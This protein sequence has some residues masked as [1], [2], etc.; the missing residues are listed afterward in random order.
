[1]INIP[2]PT[3]PK[4]REDVVGVSTSA[5]LKAKNK[6]REELDAQ[7]EEFLARGGK[8]NRVEVRASVIPDVSFHAANKMS[9]KEQE[10]R[11]KEAK[12]EAAQK[13][14]EEAE[15]ARKISERE[16]KIREAAKAVIG[17]G[18]KGVEPRYSGRK[19]A[20]WESRERIV[21]LIKM[22]GLVQAEIQR[23]LGLGQGTLCMWLKGTST[24]DAKQAKRVE[25]I[26]HELVGKV[27]TAESQPVPSPRT[28][29]EPPTVPEQ[30]Q[31]VCAQAPES[32]TVMPLIRHHL[33]RELYDLQ[34]DRSTPQRAEAVLALVDA[35][36][37]SFEGQDIRV[38]QL[39]AD[40]AAKLIKL[41][42][43][44]LAEEP[45][46]LE[47]R[48]WPHKNRPEWPNR[49]ATRDLIKKHKLNIEA[50]RRTLGHAQGVIN[51][52]LNAKNRPNPDQAKALE[53][54]VHTL[55]KE[56]RRK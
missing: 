24:P 15:K 29:D 35:I 51:C 14:R 39:T 10:A 41:T 45:A 33:V 21:A 12:A 42:Q 36:V 38:D 37:D 13:A 53:E 2:E 6:T 48:E 22:H 31:G 4:D 43:R 23:A 32:A 28:E 25:A 34:N 16:A 20:P 46:P 50:M 1:M 19:R 18:K 11:A 56:G 7:V 30:S 54:L 27:V 40:A 52:W 8:I 49:E 47:K 17:D 26:V 44:K 55:T 3:R 5:A 9:W